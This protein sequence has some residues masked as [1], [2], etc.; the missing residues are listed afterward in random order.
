VFVELTRCWENR[1]GSGDSYIYRYSNGAWSQVGKYLQGS[2]NNAYINGLDFANNTLHA[3]WTWR[4][5]PD[6]VTNHDLCYAYSAD[7]G[8]TWKN[9]AGQNLGSTITP[10]SPGIN[11][12]TIRQNSGILNQEGQTVS[13]DGTPHVLNR[14]L[15]SG[16]LT[17]LHYHRASPSSSSG[18]GSWERNPINHN[19]G[20]LTQTGRRGKLAAHPNG[21]ILA[22]LASNTG[23]DVAVLVAS[24]DD[25]FRSW[26]EIWRGKGF[27]AEP[28]YDR[29]LWRGHGGLEAGRRLSLFLSTAGGYPSRKVTV[30]DLDLEW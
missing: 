11:A 9:N 13:Q 28:L 27:D 2:D 17:W 16:T 21:E 18:S 1:S 12:F 4:E 7:E 15:R 3:T 24:P 29:E 26:K 22:I 20:S 30:V 19:L 25:G 5:T 8:K 6:V 14:E 10:S 23:N